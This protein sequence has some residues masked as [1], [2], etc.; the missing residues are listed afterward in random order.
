MTILSLK[1]LTDTASSSSRIGNA[2]E[3]RVDIFAFCRKLTAMNKLIGL[4]D[5]PTGEDGVGI[6]YYISGLNQFSL[7]CDT[8]MAISIHGALGD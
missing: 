4:T 7:N 6:G 8:P 3:K 2:I 5:S 1:L